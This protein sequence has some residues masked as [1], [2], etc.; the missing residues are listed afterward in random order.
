MKCQTALITGASSGIGEALA[1]SLAH[2][3]CR[4]ALTARRKE[5]L[6]ALAQQVHVLGGEALVYPCDT[7]DRVAVERVAHQVLNDLGHI[8][9]AVLNAGVS[10][11]MKVSQFKMDEVEG[12]LNTNLMG[13]LYWVEPLLNSML[14]R[15][16]GVLVAVSSL[17]ANRGLPGVASYSSSKA[18]LST[19]FESLRVDLHHTNVRA[20]TVEP[21]FVR[22]P[23]TTNNRAVPC[24]M[25][26]EDAARLIL[27]RIERG[28]DVIR[29]PLPMALL[30]RFLKTL[31]SWLYDGILSRVRF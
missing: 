26:V 29:F 24:L 14:A 12:V 28:K 23:L 17:A 4:L 7:Q 16:A 1:L 31:P 13:A 3:K 15:N 8:D 18:A 20:V 6:V 25:E 10:G 5:R 22:T 11:R 21:G 19:F 30:A 27:S 9:L 2:Q